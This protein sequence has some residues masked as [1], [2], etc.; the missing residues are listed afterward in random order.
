MDRLVNHIGLFQ[1]CFSGTSVVVPSGF[2]HYLKLSCVTKKEV[3]SW[4]LKGGVIQA[5]SPL[6][7]PQ[8]DIDSTG[9]HRINLFNNRRKYPYYVE[10]YAGGFD[11]DTTGGGTVQVYVPLTEVTI[12]PTR[13]PKIVNMR[14]RKEK[15][16]TALK[17]FFTLLANKL[18]AT[19][20][21]ET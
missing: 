14:F 3:T 5:L 18:Q 10:V 11:S 1:A 7:K 16:L 4:H 8:F 15:H 2:E 9:N 19:K 12:K 21:D 13:G 17:L 6:G 20:P